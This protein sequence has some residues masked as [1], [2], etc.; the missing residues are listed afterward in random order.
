MATP[1]RRLVVLILA[2]SFSLLVP[3]PAGGQTPTQQ[4]SPTGSPSPTPPVV[5]MVLLSQTPWAA[6][7]VAGGATTTAE[8]PQVPTIELRF[9]ATNLG[10][11]T[12]EDLTIGVTLFGRVLSRTAY[13]QSLVADPVPAVVIEAETLAR[14]GGI[15]PGQRRTFD[16]SLPLD[17]P[18]IDP[19]SSGIYPLKVDLRSAGV[20]LAAIR[21]PVIYLVREPEQPLELSWTFV[22]HE[23][24]AFRPDG[25]FTSTAL[26]DALRP[27]GSLT[28]QLQALQAVLTPGDTPIDVAISPVLV[29]QLLRMRDGYV[30]QTSEGTRE[31]PADE[32]GAAAADAALGSLARIATSPAVAVSALPFSAPEIPSL[33]SGGLARDLD[34]Q[35]ERGR[36]VLST[37]LGA[38]PDPSVFRPPGGALDDAAVDALAGRGIR[39][40]A[41]DPGSVE[42]PLQPLGFAPPPVTALRENADVAGLLPD[43]AVSTLIASPLVDDDPILGSQVALGELAA[44]WQELPG[45]ARGLTLVFPEDLELPGAFYGRFLQ[46]VA[47]APWLRPV[48]AADLVAAF[49]PGDPNTLA[50]PTPRSFGAFYVDELKQTRR[51]VDVYR[52]M[53]A[54]PS[55]EPERLETQL[56]LAESGDFLGDPSA[57]F[58][59]VRD[60]SAH[61][62]SAFGAVRAEAGPGGLVTLTSRSGSTIP[63]RVTNDAEEAYRVSIA[64]VSQYLEG[65]PH[66]DL[67]LGP[68]EA[69]ELTFEV[70]LK[71][72]GRFPVLIQVVA[73]IGRVVNESGFVVRSTAYSR[74]ALIITIAAAGV[75]LLLWARRFVPRRSR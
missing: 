59:F 6:S 42:S 60:A 28:R 24:I 58:A 69:R 32:G 10:V 33:I 43:P 1:M 26:E 53:L 47:G 71:A 7:P 45:Q 9:R 65:A 50:L 73:P 40:L 13:E 14:E 20:P 74:I 22:L 16:V 35:M 3:P 21:T 30:V 48:T 64:L 52:S 27:R 11:E 23:P 63:I 51:R 5:Q 56:L 8:A 54:A 34:L 38:A 25:V 70:D 49:P 18:G 44:I 36:E 37:A 68:G 39:I 75:L 55:P 72:T 15:E 57:G 66:E 4:P 29:T 67:V 2:V 46:T 19:A 17:A 31:V 41:L 61:V 62:G 12:L